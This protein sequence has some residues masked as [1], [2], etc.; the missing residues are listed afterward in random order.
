MVSSFSLSTTSKWSSEEKPSKPSVNVLNSLD[1]DKD[2]DKSKIDI[3]TVKGK[4]LEQKQALSERV[5]S[6]WTK[7]GK[8]A[9]PEGE[10]YSKR[11][12]FWMKRYE[13]FVGLTEVKA[14]Q[15]KV[16]E[17]FN[18][19]SFINEFG[20]S[21]HPLLF[22]SEKAFIA[23]QDVRRE[24]QLEIREVQEKIKTIHSELEKTH[25]GEDRY[26]SLVT[27]VR[28]VQEDIYS[29]VQL[30]QNNQPFLGQ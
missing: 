11:V 22:Q 1:P 29:T 9:A 6:W 10:W 18:A 26:L 19:S 27:Q 30:N 28:T 23:M 3:E 15:A 13:D 25:R 17:V 24:A 12:S 21:N 4:V 8:T 20:L 5:S 14:A 2:K 7:N 16:V